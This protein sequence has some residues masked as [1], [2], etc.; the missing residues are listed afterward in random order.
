MQEH[1]RPLCEQALRHLCR[2]RPRS[3]RHLP[4]G[5]Q[6]ERRFALPMLCSWGLRRCPTSRKSSR[7]SCTCA[8]ISAWPS[9][10]CGEA[11]RPE[12]VLAAIEQAAGAGPEAIIGLT[13]NSYRY[14]ERSMLS[15]LPVCAFARTIPEIVQ[16]GYLAP[17]TFPKRGPAREVIV[18]LREDSMST[19]RYDTTR[20][21]ERAAQLPPRSML[22]RIEKQRSSS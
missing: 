10:I 11:W 15:L 5:S 8:P 14:D 7:W 19:H 9:I 12:R 20:R 17:L 21:R 13:A 3:F 1:P 4:P 22:I 18:N 2:L 6:A 16:E